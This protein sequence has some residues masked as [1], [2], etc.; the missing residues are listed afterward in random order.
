MFPRSPSVRR[1]PDARASDPNGALRRASRDLISA[2]SLSRSP[3][4]RATLSLVPR[5]AANSIR[6]PISPCYEPTLDA[7][8]RLEI[9]A[10]AY[11]HRILGVLEA[12]YP[13]LRAALGAEHFHDLVTSYLLVE[14]SR[15]PSLRYAGARLAD[16][17]FSHQAA[18]GIRGRSPWAADLAA[19]EWARVD[20]FDVVDGGVL[21]RELL[22]SLAPEEFGSLLL[23][24]GPWARLNSF[25]YSVDRLW[26]AAIRGEKL[27][28]DRVTNSISVL[29]WRKDEVAVHRRIHQPEEAALSTLSLG[30][31]FEDLCERAATEV[32]VSEA[33]ARAAD[34]LGRWVAN[35]LL[36]A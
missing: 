1:T 22:A 16:F 27:V 14:P 17:L 30:A 29:I 5:V 4:S 26:G 6:L 23:R 13:A 25:E 15:H 34:W 35:G 19:F 11:F 24:L 3:I 32:G 28:V 9:Y 7:T 8:G 2:T 20:V 31:R 33:P 21:V 36:V 12:D 18:A 10:N